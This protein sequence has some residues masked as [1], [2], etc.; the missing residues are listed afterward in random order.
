MKAGVPHIPD[1]PEPWKSRDKREANAINLP[2]REGTDKM[3]QLAAAYAAANTAGDLSA[4]DFQSISLPPMIWSDD[5][6]ERRFAGATICWII[7]N[8]R[9][10]QSTETSNFKIQSRTA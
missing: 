4:A 5:L 9:P 2:L 1:L 3:K 6:L 10:A 7:H 8:T